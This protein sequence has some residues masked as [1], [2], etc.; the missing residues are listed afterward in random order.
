MVPNWL[1]LCD[2]E[3]A[4]L[5]RAA[6][7]SEYASWTELTSETLRQVAVSQGHDFAVA[8]LYDRVRRSPEHGPFIRQVEV[9]PAEEIRTPPAATL[10]IVPGAFYRERPETGADGRRLL[11]IAARLGWPAERVPVA[12]FG[13]LA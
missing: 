8:L 10:A 4:L 5:E 13:P 3:K 12:S 7:W 6:A 11:T 2:Y 9:L 1:P